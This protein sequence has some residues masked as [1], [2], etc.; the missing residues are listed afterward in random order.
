MD[1]FKN[2]TAKERKLLSKLNTP[3]KIQDY[4]DSLPMNFSEE[5]PCLCPR[6]VME[7]GTAHCMEGA[8]LAAAAL[9]YH[10]K[11]PLLL[12]L[13]ATRED[14]DH[15]VTLFRDN[16]YWGAISKTN[17]GV[18]RYREPV[19]KTV[20]ELAMSYFHEYFMHNGKKTLRTYSDPFD[21]SKFAHMNWLTSRENIIDLIV[22]MCDSPHHDM[23]P[24][25]LKRKLRKA[26]DIEIELGK[27]IEWKEKS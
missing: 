14:H 20:R 21:L 8:L 5:D 16:G 26:D 19:Y 23:V 4:L 1:Y 10:G 11:K 7:Q 22:A 27:I 25:H 2:L 15:V 17:H 3:A 12:D 24:K 9:W 18:L 13:A 6:D